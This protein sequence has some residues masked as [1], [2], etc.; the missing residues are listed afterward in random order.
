MI[1]DEWRRWI[2]ENLMLDAA[3][4]SVHAV[5]VE[6]GFEHEH[7]LCEIDSTL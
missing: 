7:A 5:L 2:A 4:E 1:D 6:H 3:P